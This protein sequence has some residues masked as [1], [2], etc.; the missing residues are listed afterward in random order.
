M[1]N[2]PRGEHGGTVEQCVQ[3]F[4]MGAC[5]LSAQMGVATCG[6]DVPVVASGREGEV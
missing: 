1:S 4:G 3:M 5:E 6:C 2:M